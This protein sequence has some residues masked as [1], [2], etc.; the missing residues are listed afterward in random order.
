MHDKVISAL[1]ID[2][3]GAAVIT[4]L[5]H[6]SEAG[7][8]GDSTADFGG[9]GGNGYL[10]SATHLEPGAGPARRSPDL[11]SDNDTAFHMH[12]RLALRPPTLR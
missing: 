3:L 1:I 8:T 5:R 10:V 12:I 2:R 11:E 4:C 7:R 9:R 6:T